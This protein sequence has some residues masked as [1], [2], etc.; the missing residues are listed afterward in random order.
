MSQYKKQKQTAAPG[1]LSRDPGIAVQEVMH[2][3]E[4]LREIYVRETNALESSDT[5]TFLALQDRKLEVA[6]LYQAQIETL[7]TRKNE[8]Q[9]VNPKIKAQLSEMQKEFSDLVSQNRSA[10]QR[11]QRTITRLGETLRKAAKEAVSK[12]RTY[13]YGESGRVEDK[14]K[15]TVSMGVIKTA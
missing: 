11:M 10:L 14:G 7:L 13:N 9:Q 6:R 2:T 12:E 4:I 8:L 5:P 3:I 1:A 15:K